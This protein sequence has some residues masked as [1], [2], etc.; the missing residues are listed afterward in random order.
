[1]HTALDVVD[2]KVTNQRKGSSGSS[3]TPSIMT[4]ADS[5]LGLLF[6]LEDLKVYGYITNTKIKFII[7]VHGA[8][9]EPNL[10]TWL[11]ELHTIYVNAMCNPFAVLNARIDTPATIG[12]TLASS[13][14][15]N[16][17]LAVTA[18]SVNR[19]FEA[20]LSKLVK[21]Y[22]SMQSVGRVK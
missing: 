14:S 9:T 1:V 19:S 16:N 12:S 17:A 13:T 22:E 10:K 15:C 8:S 5:Y 20:N 2:E 3:S 4:P 6:S 21:Q 11:R 7:V 18:A